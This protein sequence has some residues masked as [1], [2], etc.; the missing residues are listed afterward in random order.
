MR[1]IPAAALLAL[2]LAAAC[3]YD[4]RGRCA[5][6]R[7]CLAGQVCA[8]GVC[9]AET[10]G[11]I[12]HAPVAAADAYQVQAGTTLSVPAVSG[13]L[14]NDSD[15]DGDPLTAEKLADPSF[16]F[17]SVAPDGSFLYVPATGFTGDDTFA[18]RASDGV[19]WSDTTTVTVTVVP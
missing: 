10:A 5:S 1:K 7:D 19:L 17:A 12:G 13:L 11:P 18:Y 14:A 16:G 15:V 4:P 9:A 3:D 8:G 6:Q 2:A